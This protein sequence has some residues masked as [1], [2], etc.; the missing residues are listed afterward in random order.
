M[1]LIRG[2]LAGT[3]GTLAMDLLLYARY[4]KGGG[5][6]DP[7]SWE[8]AAGSN[9]WDKAAAPAQAAR[10]L[11]ATAGVDLPA[12]S[13]R[14][15]TNA[16]HW[17]YGTGW[18]ALLGLTGADGLRAGLLLGAGVRGFD[19]VSLPVLGVYK[20]IWE[21]DTETLWNDLSAHLVFGVV[22]GV[23]AEAL[24]D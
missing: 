1:R 20:P 21:Y 24:S 16:M 15:V 6:Q 17:T 14:T 2:M 4:R 12:S 19:Y 10:K 9:D 13:V 7:L 18:G 3:A 8:T 11:A 5:E 23:V 22:T